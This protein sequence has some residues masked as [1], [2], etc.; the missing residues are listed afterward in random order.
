MKTNYNFMDVRNI[1]GFFNEIGLEG[2]FEEKDGRIKFWNVCSEELDTF[3]DFNE[4]NEYA[5]ERLSHLIEDGL[6]KEVVD[7]LIEEFTDSDT[8]S[9]ESP[10]ELI[11][12]EYSGCSLYSICL[13]FKH[14]GIEHYE[15]IDLTDITGALKLV[16]DLWGIYKL[17]IIISDGSE[18]KNIVNR[19]L[20]EED[21]VYRMNNEEL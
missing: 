6:C 10:T 16:N 3:K 21:L 20:T 5:N 12:Q 9:I 13:V 7:E 2:Y 8:K 11:F 4:L 17:P 19:Y 15:K 14:E 18:K 1:E